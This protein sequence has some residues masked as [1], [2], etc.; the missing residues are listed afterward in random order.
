[1]EY[2]VYILRCSDDTL[3][4]GITNDLEHRVNVHNSGKGAK[5][6][7]SRHPV[8]VVYKELCADKSAALQREIMIKNMTRQDKLGLV[9]QHKD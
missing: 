3:Y 1:M 2:W 4:T 8:M 6:T 5:Y 9:S 7:R